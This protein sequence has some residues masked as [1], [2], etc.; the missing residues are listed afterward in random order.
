MRIYL[1]GKITK[2]GWRFDLVDGLRSARDWRDSFPVL[3]NAIFGEHD[4]VGPFFIACDH[5]CYHGETSHG[6]GL[7]REQNCG[8]GSPDL[9]RTTVVNLCFR[10]ILSADLV[11]AW[12]D[13][14]SAYGTLVEIGY[15]LGQ[16]KPVYVCFAPDLTIPQD[17][18]FAA[19]AAHR[20]M[21]ENPKE[22]LAR[23][24]HQYH[25]RMQRN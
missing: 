17:M 20:V 1:A 14:K 4:Y 21:A 7:D 8:V 3:R 9:D 25:F 19:T 22:G 10:S 23:A 2:R 13:S 18:W 15:A 16:G 5:G 11:F 24:L 6:V 12:L